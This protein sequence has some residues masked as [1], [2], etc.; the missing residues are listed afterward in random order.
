MLSP[1][2]KLDF[3]IRSNTF[4]LSRKP[5]GRKSFLKKGWLT[6]PIIISNILP[7]AQASHYIVAYINSSFTGFPTKEWLLFIINPLWPMIST[8]DIMVLSQEAC[9][10]N[11][12]RSFFIQKTEIASQRGCHLLIFYSSMLGLDV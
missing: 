2:Y 1:L 12:W 4:L 8:S 6:P 3:L 5:I 11:I 10:L 9:I 7:N